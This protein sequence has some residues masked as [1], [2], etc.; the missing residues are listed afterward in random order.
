MRAALWMAG[1]LA[2]LLTLSVAGRELTDELPVFVVMLWRSFLGVLFISPFILWSGGRLVLTRRIRWHMMRNLTHYSA[3]YCW[4]LALSLIPLAEVISI[5]FTMPLWTAILAAIFLGE[6]L[7]L[8]RIAAVAL[9]FAGILVI[10]QPGLSPVGPGQIAALYAAVVFAVSVIMTKSLTR[11]ED[12]VTIVFYM[13]LLQGLI[14]LVPAL[15]VWVW[16]SA[17]KWP[18]LLALGLA[19]TASHFCLAK[20]ITAADTGIVIPMDFLRV[21]LTAV[22]GW[23]LYAEGISLWLVLG[24]GFILLAN[25]LNLKGPSTTTGIRGIPG[26]PPSD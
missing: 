15:S 7:T 23:L 17:D 24:A 20:A 6:R 13:F 5:E 14:G 12:S 1:W 4:F 18:W 10:I 9:G 3:Q 22:L 21:P 25:T 16:P 2:A 26:R 11:T 8:R 19:G